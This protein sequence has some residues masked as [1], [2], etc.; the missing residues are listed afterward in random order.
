MVTCPDYSIETLKQGI[1]TLNLADPNGYI[2]YGQALH[3]L[4]DDECGT[5]FN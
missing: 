5:A 3:H 2:T 1:Q 4:K